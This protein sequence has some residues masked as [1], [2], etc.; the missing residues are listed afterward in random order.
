MG[1]T[2][3]AANHYTNIIANFPLSYYTVLARERVPYTAPEIPLSGQVRNIS[4]ASLDRQQTPDKYI[5][6]H[7]IRGK[8]LLSLGLKEDAAIELSLAESR[9][10]DKKTIMEIA[11]LMLRAGDYHRAQRIAFKNLQKSLGESAGGPDAEAWRLAF[12]PSFSDEVSINAEKNSLSPYLLHAIIR[13]ESSHR[14][15]AVSRAGAIGLMQLMPSTGSI[16]AKET[17]F[18]DYSTQSLYTPETNITL[19]SLYLKRL[20]DANKG[21]LPLAIASYN[22]GPNAV[23]AWISKY[24]TEE[25]DEFIEKIPYPETRNYIKRVLRSYELYGRLFGAPQIGSEKVAV[26]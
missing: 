14:A 8:A 24:G 17:G 6:F 10:G 11:G 7:L 1:M 5:S 18:R 23:S 20:I 3:E 22:A 19:G 25:M 21:S 9:C 12:L 16:M 15:D 26:R 4:P 2:E 13:E